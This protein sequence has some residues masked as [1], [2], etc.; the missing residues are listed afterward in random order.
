MIVSQISINQRRDYTIFIYYPF[1]YLNVSIEYS[2]RIILI[3]QLKPR[4]IS[5]SILLIILILSF[6]ILIRDFLALWYLSIILKDMAVFIFPY[7]LFFILLIYFLIN[8]NSINYYGSKNLLNKSKLKLILI[9][10]SLGLI[11]GNIAY[12][13]TNNYST[14]LIETEVWYYT[15]GIS[16]EIGNNDISCTLILNDKK[17]LIIYDKYRTNA[18]FEN[19]QFTDLNLYILLLGIE[20]ST[21]K[22][23]LDSSNIHKVEV[24]RYDYNVTT[25]KFH[26]IT[27]VIYSKNAKKNTCY[28]SLDDNIFYICLDDDIFNSSNYDHYEF[29]FNFDKSILYSPI[30]DVYFRIKYLDNWNIQFDSQFELL[31]SNRIDK[32]NIIPNHIKLK[33]ENNISIYDFSIY[34]AY[35]VNRNKNTVPI[36]ISV[37]SSAFLGILLS[38]IFLNNKLD[39]Q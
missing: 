2:K 14:N 35:L 8:L 34:E 1:L 25:M 27:K 10:I 22:T 21:T 23:I 17:P 33:P 30:E 4:I 7:I 3:K 37:I 16:H 13:Y 29:R 26:T 24:T 15:E 11:V 28:T 6:F 36:I 32:S 19:L 12:L 5:Y 38:F 31:S 9:S 18:K 20:N 39:S